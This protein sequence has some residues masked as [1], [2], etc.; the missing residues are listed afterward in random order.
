MT[1]KPGG[2]PDGR[3]F[4]IEPEDDAYSIG[5]NGEDGLVEPDDGDYTIKPQKAGDP[6]EAPASPPGTKDQPAR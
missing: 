2:K 6:P 1:I 4:L 3:R 5:S